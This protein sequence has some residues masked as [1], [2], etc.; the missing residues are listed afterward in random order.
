[1]FLMYLCVFS[2]YDPRDMY[3]HKLVIVDNVKE[4]SF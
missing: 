2:I 1:M 3:N 4:V